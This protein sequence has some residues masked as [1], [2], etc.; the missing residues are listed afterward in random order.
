MGKMTDYTAVSSLD[1]SDIFLIDGTNGTRKIAAED[2]AVDFAG[3]VSSNAI[4]HRNIYRGK[5][6]G[7]EVT[8]DQQAMI[9]AG[10]FDDLYTGDY[11]TIGGVNWRIADI[12]YWY[13]C[14]DTNF[15]TN[16][17]IIVP[18]K[19]LYN[20]TMNDEN[21]TD[22]GYVGSVMCTTNLETAKTTI[23]E[24]FGDLVL[25]HRDYLVNAVTSGRPS[26]GAW[27]D[28]SIEL[29]TETQVY[30]HNIYGAMANG[31]TIPTKYT[32]SKQQFALFRLDPTKVD[33][34]TTYWLQ[35][36]VSASVFANVSGH[37][38]AGYYSA[39]NSFGV[40]PAFPIGC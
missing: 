7:S 39:S 8:S 40:R 32:I 21:I 4:N 33:I 6:L 20:A 31:S 12:N 14:G 35:D 2:A 13:N 34:R 38:N 25:T 10:T 22:G 9:S 28:S 15:T 3:K 18:D 37:G 19:S 1:S 27:Y 11:W 30:G 26:A 5:Y 29:M 24:A 36:V 17:L 16:H 23:T